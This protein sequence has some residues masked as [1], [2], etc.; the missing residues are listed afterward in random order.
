MFSSGFTI[1][2]SFWLYGQKILV[3]FDP[4][5]SD[6][7]DCVGE[8]HYRRNEIVLQPH[9]EGI[10]RLPSKI[11]Q[12]FLHELMHYIFYVLGEAELRKNEQLIDGIASLLHQAM[13]T[14]NH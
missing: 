12:T 6:R 5:L 3:R 9:T 4:T 10:E 7:T 2:T 8:S 14:E 11:E 13:T 1:P